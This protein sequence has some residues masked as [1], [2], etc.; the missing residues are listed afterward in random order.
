MGQTAADFVSNGTRKIRARVPQGGGSLKKGNRYVVNTARTT[1]LAG[2]QP[3]S[4]H[5]DAMTMP[6]QSTLDKIADRQIS[7]GY[8]RR[9][10]VCPGCGILVPCTGHCDQC[11]N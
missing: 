1:V 2:D 9:N 11:W 10:K 5:G 3:Q 4:W 6:F 8:T 7:A